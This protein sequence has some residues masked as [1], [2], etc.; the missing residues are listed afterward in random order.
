MPREIRSQRVEAIVLKHGDFGE[1]DRLLTLYTREH[2]KLRALAKGVRKPGSRKSGHLEPFTRARLQLATGRDLFIVSQ[3]EAI[4]TNAALSENLEALGYA[5]YAAELLERFSA[6]NDA[7][8]SLFRLL[9]D[10]LA[11][12]AASDD[13]QLAVRYYEVRLLDQVGFR[14]ELLRCLGCG[15]QIQPEDQ[16]FSFEQGGVLCPDCGR[17][18]RS[19]HPISLAALKVLRHLQRSNYQQSQ[20]AKPGAGVQLELETL[21]NAYIT[22]LLERSLNTP[23]FLQRVRRSK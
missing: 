7:N 14:P 15:K 4:E 19:A 21:M 18:Q 23:R 13:L 17:R 11:R 8:A 9:R 6:D 5:S 1:A 20:K 16:F 12:L 10:T 3:A 2:G 22:Y